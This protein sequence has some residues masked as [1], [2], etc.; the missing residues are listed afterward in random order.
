M[1]KYNCL[2]EWNAKS[3]SL[4]GL[5]GLR[6]VKYGRIGPK[7][8]YFQPILLYCPSLPPQS[9]YA[10]NVNQRFMEPKNF[11]K[12]FTKIKLREL[13]VQL[14]YTS[15]LENSLL[16]FWAEQAI[17]LFCLINQLIR[18]CD[19]HSWKYIRQLWPSRSHELIIFV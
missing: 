14:S 7:L 4:Y 1:L 19:Q 9:K 12:L 13:Q 6:R 10:L 3:E 11:Q 2:F 16:Y 5:F 8:V 18:S 15:T 17:S